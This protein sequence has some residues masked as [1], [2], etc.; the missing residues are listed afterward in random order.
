MEKTEKMNVL[1]MEM[2]KEQKAS[3]TELF[4]EVVEVITDSF[5]AIYEREDTALIMQIPNGQKYKITV[6]ETV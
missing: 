2:K 6:Q 4:E 3:V 1:T 5:V